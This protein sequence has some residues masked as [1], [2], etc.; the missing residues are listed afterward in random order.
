MDSIGNLSIADLKTDHIE[1]WLD[2]KEW[3]D[4]TKHGAWKAINRCFR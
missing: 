2:S 3:A 1:S 4:S